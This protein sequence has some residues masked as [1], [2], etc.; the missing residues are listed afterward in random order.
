MYLLKPEEGGMNVPVA[1]YF[2][3]HIF[4][5]TWDTSC[6]LKIKGKDF[7]MPGEAGE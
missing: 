2:R 3:K 4:S 5:L 1:N 7:I 6:R